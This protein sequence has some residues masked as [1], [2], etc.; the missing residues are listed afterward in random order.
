[1]PRTVM[2]NAPDAYSE[3]VVAVAL[4]EVTGGNAGSARRT[5]SSTGTLLSSAA[6][7]WPAAESSSGVSA[8]VA[9]SQACSQSYRGRKKLE[10]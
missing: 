3:A 4:P 1:M 7:T 2:V 6:S 8:A 10:R 9:V 5:P